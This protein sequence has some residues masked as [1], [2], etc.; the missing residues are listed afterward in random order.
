[1]SEN[2]KHDMSDFLNNRRAFLFATDSVT[3]APTTANLTTVPSSSDDSGGMSA[4]FD[5]EMGEQEKQ[6]EQDA[7]QENKMHQMQSQGD[8]AL[9]AITKVTIS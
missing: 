7:V 8:A 3:S 2:R 5:K 4:L 1:F 9:K 6:Y